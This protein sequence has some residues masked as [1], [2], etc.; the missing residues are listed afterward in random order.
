MIGSNLYDRIMKGEPEALAHFKDIVRIDDVIDPEEAFSLQ[1]AAVGAAL[2]QTGKG[3]GAAM[4]KIDIY[5]N[6]FEKLGNIRVKDAVGRMAQGVPIDESDADTERTW[7]YDKLMMLALCGPDKDKEGMSAPHAQLLG[8]IES[9]NYSAA[10]QIGKVLAVAKREGKPLD[11]QFES[12]ANRC[13]ANA[14]KFA[15]GET[16]MYAIEAIGIA[17][18]DEARTTAVNKLIDMV[19]LG[20]GDGK[21]A[22]MGTLLK[23]F[24]DD[25]FARVVIHEI[26]LE[27]AE[28]RSIL[29]SVAKGSDRKAAAAAGSIMAD[30]RTE[31]EVEWMKANK[32]TILYDYPEY[33]PQ[34]T[35]LECMFQAIETVMGRHPSTPRE[36]TEYEVALLQLSSSGNPGQI[37]A[38]FDSKG[39]RLNLAKMAKDVENAL[40]YALNNG[41][42]AE[43]RERAAVGLERIGSERVQD[44]LERIAQRHGEDTEVGS[45][46]S[47]ALARIRGRDIMESAVEIKAFRKPPTPQAAARLAAPLHKISQ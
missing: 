47:D 4:A 17:G 8:R 23:Y 1:L 26:A 38:L 15:T 35:Y 25:A 12:L 45:L 24:S 18:N 27:N 7:T 39:D 13:L 10:I 40:L 37:E 20:P 42:S 14:A 31:N 6:V 11:P 22:A 30:V 43:V 9:N 46:A 5:F 19:E 29:A 2:S 16:A 34:R 41:Y 44:I 33:S 21:Q 28:I 36:M 32:E 3:K